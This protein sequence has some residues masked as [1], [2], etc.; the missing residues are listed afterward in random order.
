[1]RT[2]LPAFRE[3]NTEIRNV[4]ARRGVETPTREQFSAPQLENRGNS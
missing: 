3:I 2:A 1:M 4:C